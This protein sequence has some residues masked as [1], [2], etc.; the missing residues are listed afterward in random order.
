MNLITDCDFLELLAE[1]QIT[2][3]DCGDC[4]LNEFF[5][6]KALMFQYEKLGQTFYGILKDTK[7]IIC[8]FSLSADSVKTFLLPGSRIK[9]IK[10]F[11]PRE[12]ALQT[13]PAMLIGRLGVS[14]DFSGRGVG[15]QLLDYIKMYCHKRFNNVAR[16]LVVDAYNNNSVLSFYQKNDFSFLF[17]TEEQEKENLRKKVSDNEILN[18]R[19][20]FYD[21]KRWK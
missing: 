19:Q 6:Q 11:I 5:I 20:M 3:F 2:N 14:V 13:Y 21:M 18:T 12:K 8:A 17:S 1:N 16:F 15:S 10:E 7:K 9:K 4:D